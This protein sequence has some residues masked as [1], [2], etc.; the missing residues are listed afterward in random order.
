TLPKAPPGQRT[1]IRYD[2]SVVEDFLRHLP[3]GLRADRQ[4]GREFLQDTVRA[5]RIADEGDRPRVCP[6][7]HEVLGKLTPQHLAAHG[8]T[9]HEGYRRFPELGFNKR[10]RLV[11]QPSPDGLLKT[12]EVFGLMVAGAGFEPATFGL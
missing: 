6:V 12:G 2:R 8:L 1:E 11:I 5:I 3:A 9:L 7:C 10:A 4:R